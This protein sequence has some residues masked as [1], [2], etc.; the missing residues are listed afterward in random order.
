MTSWHSYSSIYNLGH[1]ALTELFDGPVTVEEKV[2]GSQFSF[3]VFDGVLRARSKGA[4]LN[5]VA[6]EQMF[7]AGI[8]RAQELAEDGRLRDGWTYRGEYL[9][10]P[11]HNTLCYSRIP[12]GHVILFDIAAAEEAY[13][14]YDD[15]AREAERLGLEVVP[16]LHGGEIEDQDMFRA[17]L[18]TTSILGGQK[19]EG[20]VVKNYAKFGPDKKT[21]MGKFVSE[22][23]KEVHAGE[24]RT[25]NPTQGDIVQRLI[26]KYRTPARWQKAAQHLT[27]RGQ[28][29]GD[30]R[31]IGLLMRE[32]PLD[33]EKEEVD[34]IKDALYEFAW[35]KVRRGLTAGLPEW[36]KDV[37]LRRQFEGVEEV[38]A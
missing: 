8:K 31:D 10:K 29:A 12:A 1:K 16:R 11:K 2:D 30:P 17:L 3:G 37:L 35:P 33:V 7:L 14:G 26:E 34:A 5:L 20:V 9:A 13:L 19:V 36:Y 24:W 15:K 4:E 28:L 27:E 6:P 22:Q 21:L 23:F 32:V 38:T 18:D 25:A